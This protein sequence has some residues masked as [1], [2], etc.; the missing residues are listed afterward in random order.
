MRRL[1][2]I[3][4]LVA[5]SAS[6]V[7]APELIDIVDLGC[8]VPDVVAQADAGECSFH[9]LSSGECTVSFDEDV[10]WV[11]IIKGE[12]FNGDGEVVL[13]YSYN[14]GDTRKVSLTVRCGGWSL[15]LTLTQH[16][17]LTS[18]LKFDA[19]SMM[20]PSANGAHSARLV[21]L[22]DLSESDIDIFYEGEDGWIDDRTIRIDGADLIFAVSENT[23]SDRR[24]ATVKVSLPSGQSASVRIVQQGAQEASPVLISVGDARKLDG[25][26]M[27]PEHLLVGRAVNDDVE[28][29]GGQ[30]LNYSAVAQDLTLS[31]RTV[32]LQSLD[33]EDGRRYGIRVELEDVK[34]NIIH[35]Y[36]KVHI[37]LDGKQIEKEYAEG[38]P[39]RYVLKGVRAKDV[40]MTESGA[41]SDLPLIEKKFAELT[42]EDIHTFVTLTDCAIPVR[43]GPFVPIHLVHRRGMNKYPMT[44]LDDQGSCMYMLTNTTAAWARDGKGMPQGSGNVS[45]VI[46]HEKCDNFEWDTEKAEK[47]AQTMLADYV[48][49]I[50]YIGPYQIRPVSRDDIA[51]ASGMEISVHKLIC[52]WR[53]YNET[54][55]KA[56]LPNVKDGVIYATWPQVEDPLAEGA[57]LARLTYSGYG[58]YD[59]MQLY[60]MTDWTHL[61]PVVN[62]KIVDLPGSFGVEDATGKDIHWSPYSSLSTSAVIQSANGSAFKANYW[63]SAT[64]SHTTPRLEE[65]HWQ[66]DF[67]TAELSSANAPLSVQIGAVN[68]D[69][70]IMG[71]PRYWVLKWSS[72]GKTWNTLLPGAYDGEPF[73]DLTGK[74]GTF[75][76]KSYT[77]SVPEFPLQADRKIYNCPGY[78]YMSFTLPSDADVWGKEHVYVR[79]HAAMDVGGYDGSY[80]SDDIY[81]NRP[82]SMNYAAVRCCK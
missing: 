61:G 39:V 76:G 62:N 1:S 17:V 68:G 22:A 4:A 58:K 52:E 7:K 25:R 49:D 54:R 48:S 18:D 50:G 27:G 73:V 3:L 10:S 59:Y 19:G 13:E 55:P 67:S 33:E 34:D 35:R 72:D 24:Y 78:K 31:S 80:D 79:L 28:G 63:Y 66:M 44:L 8:E 60:P 16:G 14:K 77:Y 36:D 64:N 37:C 6:C 45:G 57:S 70:S 65:Y 46:V 38:E 43:K 21:S 11:S 40:V 75:S 12:A 32:Y 20:V 15:P 30:N 29:N 42:D 81:N 47:K 53:Y 56:C 82:S 69:G 9:I 51:L 5:L 74:M 23:S 41:R 26:V 2:A 71:A